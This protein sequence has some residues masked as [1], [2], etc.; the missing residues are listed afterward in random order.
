MFRR[1]RFRRRLRRRR[2]RGGGY[3][4]KFTRNHGSARPT[5]A[6]LKYHDARG[7]TVAVQMLPNLAAGI[8]TITLNNVSEGAGGHQRIGRRIK[9]KSLQIRINPYL[10]SQA[11]DTTVFCEHVRVMLVY[12]AQVNGTYPAA[13]DM[14]AMMNPTGGTP[15]FDNMAWINLNNRER[16]LMLRQKSWTI[17]YK[18]D[19]LYTAATQASN[20]YS[21][22]FN[23]YIKLRGLETTFN[24]NVTPGAAT[25]LPA[26]ISTGALYLM[27]ICQA[28]K[29][30]GSFATGLTNLYVYPRLRFY[31]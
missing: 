9:M 17:Q 4:R 19:N 14:L 5:L 18:P 1:R 6:E 26:E 27:F 31:D 25:L 21:R 30:D 23:W 11:A 24:G 13:A 28:V 22:G 12:D 7:T 8:R 3:K 2:G 15:D 29:V 10:G 16:F 20:T